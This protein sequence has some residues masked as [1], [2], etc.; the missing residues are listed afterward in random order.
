MEQEQ[1]TEEEVCS[2]YTQLDQNLETTIHYD[3]NE[4]NIA[5]KISLTKLDFSNGKHVFHYITKK[6]IVKTVGANPKH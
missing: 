3:D 5:R 4:N 6:G 1:L 2:P